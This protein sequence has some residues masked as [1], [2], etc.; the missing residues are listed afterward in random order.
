[1]YVGADIGGT[2]L[3]VGD[4][5]ENSSVLIAGLTADQIVG[6]IRDFCR[7]K[8]VKAIGVG[9]PGTLDKERRVILNTPNLHTL[10]GYNLADA[11]EAAT[12]ARAFLENDTVALMIS[13]ADLLGLD[14]DGTLL[15]IYIGTGLGSAVFIGGK[16]YAGKNG[17]GPEIGHVPLLGKR[18]PCGCGNFGCAEAYVSGS[19]LERLRARKYPDTEIAEIFGAMSA[20]ELDDYTEALAVTIAGAVQILDPDAVILGGG[21]AAMKG[22]PFAEVIRKVKERTMK[23]YP[24]ENLTVLQS[25]VG[26]DIPA[27]VHGAALLAK[28]GYEQL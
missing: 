26:G 13:D 23:P 27:G 20:Q 9:I 2:R 8:T 25:P 19:F 5:A 18:E 14:A 21:V 7:G 11:L 1:M 4:G 16:P 17:I 24:S 15:G 6:H 28:R 3:R 10:N 22:F 12:G